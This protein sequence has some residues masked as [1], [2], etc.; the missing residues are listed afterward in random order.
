MTKSMYRRSITVKEITYSN[1]LK[2][3]IARSKTVDS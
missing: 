3:G 1:S 2:G